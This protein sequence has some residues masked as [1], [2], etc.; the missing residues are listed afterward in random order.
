[1][2]VSLTPALEFPIIKSAFFNKVKKYS[3]LVFRRKCAPARRPYKR[4]RSFMARNDGIDR[5]S[6]LLYT[7]DAQIARYIN[8]PRRTVNTLRHKAYRLLTELM[9][10]EADD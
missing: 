6:C 3:N 2:E 5:I 4:E 8:M 7:S 10:G 1:M 9:G